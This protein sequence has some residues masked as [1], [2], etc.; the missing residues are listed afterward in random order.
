M[1]LTVP[2]QVPE[3][4]GLPGWAGNVTVALLLAGMTE[5]ST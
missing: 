2:N 4:A 1:A 5:E 3:V